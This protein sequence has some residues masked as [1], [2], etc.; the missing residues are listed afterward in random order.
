VAL[1]RAIKAHG[2]VWLG[3][4]ALARSIRPYATFADIWRMVARSAYV[5]L[6]FSPLLLL[7]TLLGLFVAFLVPPLAALFSHGVARW[8]GVLAWALMAATLL[9]TLRR[10]HLSPLRALLLPAMAAFYMAATVGSALDHHRGRG[11]V[12]K[13]R[14]YTESQA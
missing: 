4:S 12:W 6:D 1:A 10:F 11:V 8:L 14:A 3:H 7:G 2:A 13:R 5:Q 9:P